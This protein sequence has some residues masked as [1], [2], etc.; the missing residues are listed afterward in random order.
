MAN[1]TQ[2]QNEQMAAIRRLQKRR[3][4]ANVTEGQ[5][6]H[7]KPD[8]PAVPQPARHKRPLRSHARSSAAQALPK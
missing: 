1:E 3:R 4:L 7:L 2:L 8:L 6:N 5:L